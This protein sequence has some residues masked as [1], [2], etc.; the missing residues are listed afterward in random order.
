[1]QATLV[2][3]VI[4]CFNQ[5]AYLPL[6]IRSALH[7][8]DA[9]VEVI[10]VNDGSTDDTRQVVREFASQ[11]VAIEQTNQGVSAARNAG[12]A[13]AQGNWIVFL[14]ADD[15]LLEGALS[16]MLKGFQCCNN[17]DVVYGGARLI[18]ASGAPLAHVFPGNLATHSLEQLL[19][20]NR[21]ATPGAVCLRRDLCTAIGPFD[22]AVSPAED[23]DYWIRA[24]AAGAR[25]QRIEGTL[26]GYRQHPGSNSRRY[27]KLLDAVRR[28]SAKHRNLTRRS[29]SLWLAWL[30]GT[31]SMRYFCWTKVLCPQ[32]SSA[33]RAGRRLESLALF[34]RAAFQDC[35]SAWFVFVELLPL[36]LLAR[37]HPTVSVRSTH[38]A[39]A[40]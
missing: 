40:S 14:D 24:A 7:Q 25:F 5:A 23:W 18:D 16:Q 10:V 38:Q 20:A 12:L 31:R 13:A 28:V 9:A 34:C 35:Y 22:S 3:I 33:W 37:R 32:I 29:W 39:P 2:S 17:A 36:T 21:L 4:P 26:V 6:A 30:C 27:F 19:A 1:M 11:I 15:I 8:R